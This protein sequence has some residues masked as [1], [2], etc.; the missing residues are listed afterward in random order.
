MPGYIQFSNP[1]QNQ[2]VTRYNIP[3]LSMNR[4][5]FSDNTRVYYKQNSQ[6]SGIGSVRN[7]SSVR[8]RT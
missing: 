4:P 7:A 1:V 5:I 2:F 3:L 6:S 8:H